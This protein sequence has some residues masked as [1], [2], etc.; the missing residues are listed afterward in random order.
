MSEPTLADE[1]QMRNIADFNHEC[2]LE[3]AKDLIEFDEALDHMRRAIEFA[4]IEH[5]EYIHELLSD[6]SQPVI[7]EFLIGES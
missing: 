4:K 3:R 7:D 6:Y 2:E 5:D 1:E